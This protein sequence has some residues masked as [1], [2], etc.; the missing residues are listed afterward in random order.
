MSNGNDRSASLAG[1]C[2]PV[3]ET[4]KLYWQGRLGG[5]QSRSGL[6]SEDKHSY[7]YRELN[8]ERLEQRLA[9]IPR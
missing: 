9:A 8:P 5:P 3:K 1:C 6:G 7:F 2:I 4:I